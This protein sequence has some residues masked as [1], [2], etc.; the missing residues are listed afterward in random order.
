M[1]YSEYRAAG[2]GNPAGSGAAVAARP[3]RR[4]IDLLREAARTDKYWVLRPEGDGTWTLRQ[5]DGKTGLLGEA[6]HTSEPIGDDSTAAIMWAGDLV[7]TTA[8][9]S[10]RRPYPG[11]FVDETYTVV[12]E[13]A[14]QTRPGR[15]IVV[16][17]ETDPAIE[18]VPLL[19]IRERWLAT[20]LESDPL[21]FCDYTGFDGEADT[22]RRVS[23]WFGLDPDGWTTVKPGVEW[24]HR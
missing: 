17:I 14:Y 10:M 18:G 6:A 7:D 21:Y 12:N 15:S 23:D 4:P 24:R 2:R 5:L 19:V 16:R 13:L 9:H 20:D 11:A 22:L 8:W 1:R 3:E